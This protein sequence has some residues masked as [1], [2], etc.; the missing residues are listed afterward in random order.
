MR[1]ERR[2]FAAILIPACVTVLLAAVLLAVRPGEARA[3]SVYGY[4]LP[5]S[6]YTYLDQSVVASWPAQVVCY[7]K[8]EIYA[9]KGRIFTGEEFKRYFESKSWYHGTVPAEEFDKNQNER[10]NDIERANINK[11]VRIAE[12]RGLR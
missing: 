6:S 1:T 2:G 9:R 12:E 8:N 7:A 11:L 5:T 4:L 10:F 3:D